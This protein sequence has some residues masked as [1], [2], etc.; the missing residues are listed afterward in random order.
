MRRMNSASCVRGISDSP[1]E[2]VDSLIEAGAQDKAF[3]TETQSAQRMHRE[4]L[5][6]DGKSQ[7]AN[8]QISLR[9]SR[10]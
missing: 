9:D 10:Q 8:V 5:I 3:T 1:V 2:D 4:E 7:M 6:S